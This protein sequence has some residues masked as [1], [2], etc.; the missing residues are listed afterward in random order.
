[1]K[2]NEMATNS[3]ITKTLDD[4]TKEYKIAFKAADKEAY[5]SYKSEKFKELHEKVQFIIIE[6]VKNFG[7]DAY[8]DIIL[9]NTK[10]KFKKRNSTGNY[11]DL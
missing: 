6:I 9:P 8:M 11:L 5:I 7:R 10:G 3:T 1:M 4:L 2:T